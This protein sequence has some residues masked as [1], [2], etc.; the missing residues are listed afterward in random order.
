M[1]PT[2]LLARSL[3][4]LNVYE[5]ISLSIHICVNHFK[6]AYLTNITVMFIFVFNVS[7]VYVLIFSGVI[8]FQL[9]VPGI[10][11]HSAQ[12][13]YCGGSSRIRGGRGTVASGDYFHTHHCHPC[14]TDELS[15]LD[16]ME[17]LDSNHIGFG[18]LIFFFLPFN[19]FKI[20]NYIFIVEPLPK[21]MVT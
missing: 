5:A 3:C 14:G 11:L 2:L 16:E 19:D 10:P 8:M 4:T 21:L 7:H 12:C 6:L 15:L 9:R 20:L 13:D 1:V 17:F 18:L